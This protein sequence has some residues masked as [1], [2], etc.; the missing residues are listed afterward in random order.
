M[1]P[2]AR[3]LRSFSFVVA[4][5]V[6]LS[7]CQAPTTPT[8]P[9]TSA[10][11]ATSAA[12]A[13]T[14]APATA[15]APSPAAQPAASPV[16]SPSPVPG[17]NLTGTIKI[18]SSFPRTGYWKEESDSLVR[19]IRMALSEANN[20]VGNATLVYEDLDDATA[21]KGSWD[22]AREAENATKAAMSL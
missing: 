6:I 16:P 7:G 3:L 21:A 5:S 12:S 17:A 2:G 20:K 4:T 10:P 1:L 15:A 19:A 13:P 22:A 18:V 14:S 8:A 9:P 11:A